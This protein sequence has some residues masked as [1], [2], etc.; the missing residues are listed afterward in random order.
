MKPEHRWDLSPPSHIPGNTWNV[1]SAQ[2]PGRK[3]E[4]RFVLRLPTQM[5]NNISEVEVFLTPRAL[6]CTAHHAAPSLPLG[7]LSSSEL[8]TPLQSRVS[9][10]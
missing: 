8:G 4:S 10:S 6:L 7:Q 9:P 5:A 2:E 3:E 1:L